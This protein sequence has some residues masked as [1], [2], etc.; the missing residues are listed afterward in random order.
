VKGPDAPK[1]HARTETWAFPYSYR[2]LTQHHAYAPPAFFDFSQA[3]LSEV[4][5]LENGSTVG[6]HYFDAWHVFKPL[7]RQP[8][9]PDTLFLI[10]LIRSIV[11][12]VLHYLNF[13]NYLDRDKMMC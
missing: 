7:I 12:D 1:I 5:R 6:K 2:S 10:S 11:L 4:A 13:L 9:S 8:F 3:D